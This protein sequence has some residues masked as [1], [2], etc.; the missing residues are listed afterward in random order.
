MVST[1]SKKERMISVILVLALVFF[2]IPQNKKEEISEDI[3]QEFTDVECTLEMHVIDVGQA[4]CILIIQNDTVMLVDSG[5]MATGDEVVKYLK[6]LGITKIDVLVATHQHHDHIGG[7][8]KVIDNFEVG[9]IYMPDL[10]NEKIDT[11]S[12]LSF[13]SAIEKWSEN[14]GND[15]LFPIDNDGNLREFELGQAKVKF[16]A[17]NSNRYLIKNNYSIVIR[18]IFGKTSILLAADAEKLS[19]KEMMNSGANLKS[20]VLKIG[21]H[22]CKSSTTENFLNAVDPTYAILSVGE[23]NDYKYPDK[24]VINRFKKREIPVYRTDELGT[25]IMI[26]DGESITFNSP[27]GTYKSGKE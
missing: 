27:P 8:A 6:D 11:K 21:H 3:I 13:I 20:D 1:K 4:D 2:C 22:G 18:I 5:A 17:P 9:V 19:E 16:L 14:S 25:V 23:N 12:Y 15:I 7:M 26:T 10:H 24:A